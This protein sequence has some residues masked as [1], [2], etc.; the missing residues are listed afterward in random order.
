MKSEVIKLTEAPGIL[1]A[2][3]T[4][5]GTTELEV[6]SEMSAREHWAQVLLETSRQVLG[7]SGS[8]EIKITFDKYSVVVMQSG[9]LTLG[10]VVVKSHP[11]VKSLK[12][13]LRRAFKRLGNAVPVPSPKAPT[14]AVPVPITDVNTAKLPF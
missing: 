8:D 5:N 6:S 10:V 2:S 3:K 9:P 11:V 7:A 1:A 13:M 14:L 4:Q 12:R